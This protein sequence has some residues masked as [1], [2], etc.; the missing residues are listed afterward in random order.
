MCILA[1][2]NNKT[3]AW[4]FVCFDLIELQNSVLHT[5]SKNFSKGGLA[6]LKGRVVSVITNPRNY[7]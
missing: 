2:E 3:K 5:K 7:A 4:D 6:R 1:L